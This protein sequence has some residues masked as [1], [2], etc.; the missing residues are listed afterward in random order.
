MVCKSCGGN[1]GSPVEAL[2]LA[3]IPMGNCTSCSKPKSSC[4]CEAFC[5]EDH[6][7]N[8]IYKHFGFTIRVKDAFVWPASGETVTLKVSGVDRLSIGT[9]LW[10]PSAGYLHVESFDYEHQEIIAKNEG[11]ACNTYVGGESLP[12]CTDFIPGPAPCPQGTPPLPN[13]PYLA[14]DFISIADGDCALASVTNIF[15]LTLND[16][17]SVNGYE[18][19][20]GNII[21]SDTIQLCNDGDG[22]PIGTVIFWDED[23]DEQPNIP[24]F[25]VSS[26]NPCSRSEVNVGKLLVCDPGEVSRPM[27]GSVSGQIPVWNQ[28]TQRFELKNLSAPFQSCVSLTADLTVDPLHVGSYIVLVTS[29]ANFTALGTV[30]IEGLLYTV[31][32]VDDA[33]T[34]HITPLITPVAVHTY[35]TGT[36]VCV[37][38]TNPCTVTGIT[39]GVLLVCDGSGVSKPLVGSAT[40]Q[41]ASWNDATARFELNT[42]TDSVIGSVASATAGITDA[43]NAVTVPVSIVIANPNLLR[44]MKVLVCWNAFIKWANNTG[45]GSSDISYDIQQSENGGAYASIFPFLMEE[46]WYSDIPGG[47]GKEMKLLT[48]NTTQVIAAGNSLNLAGKAVLAANP[49]GPNI[50]T[51]ASLQLQ[52][53]VLGV[54]V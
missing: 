33:T 2:P 10:N 26:E 30:T 1:G 3:N 54:A 5:E 14:A 4:Q 32:S 20:V 36:A 8:T 22:A 15:G 37:A 28:L 25:V 34:M 41:V 7:H 21:D 43:K 44:A 12:E 23:G 17:V 16:I 48:Q 38:P 49:I 19:R 24:L 50:F 27:L 6:V 53:K 18:Y 45:N 51:S 39:A 46:I 9:L 31:N 35:P 11:E 13:V 29:T 47:P 40:G 42:G 52:I